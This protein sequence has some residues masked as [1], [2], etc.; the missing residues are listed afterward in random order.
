MTAIP[1]RP[2]S[3]GRG[4]IAGPRTT[5]LEDVMQR[6][7][8]IGS[9]VSLVML[10]AACGGSPAATQGPGAA[11]SGPGGGGGS[12]SAPVATTD[13]GGG[14]GGGGTGTVKYEVTG[15]LQ[16][17]GELPFFAVGSRFGGAAGIGL[18]F[19]T[20]A[21]GAIFSIVEANGQHA[22]SLTDEQHGLTWA[23][24]ETYE[25]NATGSSATGRFDCSQGFGT[26]IADGTMVTDIHLT[27]TFE[28][29]T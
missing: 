15:T 10:L 16:K 8:S 17:S 4:A 29:R 9:G 18:T 28:A 25:M 26:V 12:T 21:G 22:I 13:G 27:G 3:Q 20:E 5:F 14:S 23:S 6:L 7:R 2:Q 1:P 24:C 19:T 11:T